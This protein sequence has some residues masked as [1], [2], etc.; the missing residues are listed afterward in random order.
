MTSYLTSMTTGEE[1]A[2]PGEQAE[3]GS[4]LVVVGVNNFDSET[5]SFPSAAKMDPSYAVVTD[6]DGGIIRYSILRS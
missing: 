2:R 5:F 6:A 1:L 3:E 4:G